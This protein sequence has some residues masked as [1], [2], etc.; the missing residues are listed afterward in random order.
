MRKIV[1]LLSL[2]CVA[3]A[4]GTIRKSV[5]V[6]SDMD[7]VGGYHREPVTWD[8]ARFAPHVSF[9]AGDGEEQWLFQSFL[10]IESVDV[11]RG[12]HFSLGPDGQSAG[13]ESWEDMLQR[14][15]G[16]D[17]AVAA[18]DE[19]CAAAAARIGKPAQKRQVII[20]L[21]DAVMFERFADKHSSTTYWG[22][23]NGRQ[24]DFSDVQDQ[25]AAYHWYI[26]TAREMFRKLHC[27][28]LELGGF[29]VLSEELHLSYGETPMER[30]NCQY[31]RWEEIVPAL[32][33]YCHARAEGLWWI[34]YHMAPGYRHWKKLGF[35]MAFMQPN[36]YWDLYYGNHPFDK[37]LEAIKAFGMGME[38]E[39]EFSAVADQMTGGVMGPDGAGKLVFRSS[40]VPAL[41]DRLRYYMQAFKEAGLYGVAPLAVYSGSNA[42]TQ[43][44]V[45][46]LP[47][48][49]A[50]YLELCEFVVGARKAFYAS[51]AKH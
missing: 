23:V 36:W 50:L 48:D 49:Q 9:T 28:Y 29:Y 38:L 7:L 41:Q 2:A 11:A 37:T 4:C 44:A 27:K 51:K 22:A 21:P 35:D 42:L 47:Q 10:M 25:L 40:D 45:S 24:L 14:W 39:F 1:L 19:A 32:S 26:D 46:P 33:E 30:L 8:A 17:G 43:L 31:K 6:L 12:L 13:R 20:T 18:L 5:P 16:P 3:A 34:P 15:L